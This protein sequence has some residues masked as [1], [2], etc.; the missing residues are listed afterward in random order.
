MAKYIKIAITICLLAWVFQYI[1]FKDLALRFHH[2]NTTSLFVA[3]LCHIAAFILISFRWWSLLKTKNASTKYRDI[4][5]SFYLGLFF[6]NFLPTGIGGDVVKIVRLHKKGFCTTSLV[7]ST[8]VDRI[9]GLYTIL[10]L[11]MYALLY[12]PVY[13]VSDHV[14][15]T[16]LILTLG[17]PIIMLLINPRFINIFLQNNI[18]NSKRRFVNKIAEIVE[19]VFDYRSK[20]KAITIAIILSLLSQIFIVL[21]YIFIGISLNIEFDTMNYLIVVPIV[22]LVSSLPISVGGHGV[23]EGTIIFVFTAFSA[24]PQSAVALSV[25]YLSIIILLT[26]PGG[27]VLLRSHEKINWQ[28]YN[29]NEKLT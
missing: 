26:L 12:S 15:L 20:F 5:G 4:V 21:C 10:L 8:I 29:T 25:I 2:A 28:D 13:I 6:N 23:R 18:K 1:D 7:S 19:A 16:M 24:N 9:I 22:F 27:L 17:S 3:F 11:G 14:A